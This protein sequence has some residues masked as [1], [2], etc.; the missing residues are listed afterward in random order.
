MHIALQ[1]LNPG[2]QDQRVDARHRA[3]ELSRAA[4]PLTQS[5]ETDKAVGQVDEPCSEVTRV[6]Q[7][8]SDRSQNGPQLQT[9][10]IICSILQSHAT[11][12]IWPD[13]TLPAVMLA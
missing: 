6:L 13:E 9:V 11:S 8:P 7:P 2:G 12:S 3:S 5:M 10:Y 4:A 1:G